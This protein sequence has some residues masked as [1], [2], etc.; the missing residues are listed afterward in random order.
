MEHQTH[1]SDG[2]LRA[3]IGADANPNRD[4][5]AQPANGRR[6]NA[7]KKR[8]VFISNSELGRFVNSQLII[9]DMYAFYVVSLMVVVRTFI[10]I[11]IWRSLLRL[12][13]SSA[14][15]LIINII[16]SLP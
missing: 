11:V 5:V 4:V 13:R 9:P 6:Q 7:G 14:R 12:I 8:T 1:L 3:R 16:A 2:L 15:H 10:S